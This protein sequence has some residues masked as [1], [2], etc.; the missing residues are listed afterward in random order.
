MKIISTSGWSDYYLL[1]S[2]NGQ[3]LECFGKYTLVRPDP[4]AIWQPNLPQKEWDKADAVFK[5]ITQDRGTWIKKN[6]LPDKWEMTWNNIRFWSKLTP[7]KHTGIFPEQVSQWE[8]MQS[9]IQN[10]NNQKQSSLNILN[11]FAYTGLAT[12]A[13]AAAGTKVTHVDASKP[14]I[15]WAKENQHLSNLQDKPIRWIVDDAFK[16]VQRELKRGNKY[17]GVI[18]DPP[19]YGHGPT[20]EI[21]KFN[22]HFPLLLKTCTQL[23]SDTPLFIVINAY[24]ISASSLMLEN[25]LKD[26][27]KTGVIESGELAIE[28]KNGKRQLSTGIFTTWRPIP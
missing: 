2:G 21:W 16:F 28:E 26:F 11:L 7:F 15:T 23:L 14:S 1:D 25:V 24:A 4:Q 22:D 12:L 20:G 10:A 13:C 27:I 8:L 6:A 5:R 3:K 9:A 17:D 18:M 19:I